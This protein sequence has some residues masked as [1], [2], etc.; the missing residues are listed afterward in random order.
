MK[1]SAQEIISELE[2]RVARL[3]KEALG[4]ATKEYKITYQYYL[5]PE[6]YGDTFASKHLLEE[7]SDMIDVKIH[8]YLDSKGKVKDFDY[9]YNRLPTFSGFV[10]IEARPNTFTEEFEK[11]F[12]VKGLNVDVYFEAGEDKKDIEILATI[13]KP[14]KVDT[15]AWEDMLDQGAFYD[16]VSTLL[17]NYKVT[18]LQEDDSDW[19]RTKI[20][21]SYKGVVKTDLFDKLPKRKKLPSGYI[22]TFKYS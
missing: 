20:E 22:V 8:E 13:K 21:L 15:D 1:K 10:I 17:R 18:D 9:I 6:I 2:L 16:E 4:T 11:T 19:S 3:E 5:D 14:R 7:K 12:K